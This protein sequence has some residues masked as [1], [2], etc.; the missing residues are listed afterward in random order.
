MCARE[1]TDRYSKV[2]SSAYGHTPYK[3][4]DGGLPCLFSLRACPASGGK[5]IRNQEAQHP[6]SSEGAKSWNQIGSQDYQDVLAQA[7]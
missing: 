7:V 5:D 1:W 6:P 2:D 3:S 4:G